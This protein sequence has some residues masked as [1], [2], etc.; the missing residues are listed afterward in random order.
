M[1]AV[2]DAVQAVTGSGRKAQPACEL[3]TVDF[4]R[5]TGQRA[6]AQWADIQTF[7]GILQTAFVTRQ[8]LNIG[9]TP[10]GK[11]HRLRALQVGIA[12]HHGVLVVLRGLYQRALQLTVS[13]QQLANGLFTPQLQ[14]GS[15]LVVTATAGV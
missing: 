7:Q 10:V 14:V 13:C 9:Q 5:G 8:H 3:F 15:N 1:I 4:I 6:A 12:R 11:G 2:R